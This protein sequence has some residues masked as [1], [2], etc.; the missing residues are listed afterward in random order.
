MRIHIINPLADAPSYHSAE[1]YAAWGGAR[2]TT[3]ADLATVTLAAFVP[4]DWEIR[5]TDEA[6]EPLGPDGDLGDECDIVA[7]TGKVSQRK[8]M[9][10][11]ANAYRQRG[12]LVLMGG[13]YASLSPDDLRPHADILV[14]G[15]IEDIAAGLFADLA[16]GRW[17]DRYVG[18][19]P[20]LRNSPIPRW[21]LYPYHG[22]IMGTLQT[23]RGCPFTCDFCDVIQY[24]GRHQRH[25]APEQVIA[26]LEVLYRHGYRRI[27]LAD[28]NFT[29]YR[30]HA[31]AVLA[32]F[33]AWNEAHRDDPVWFMAQVS[34]DLARDPELM[35]ACKAAGL[36][37]VFIGIETVNEDSLRA[38]G[39]RQNLY[40]SAD[41]ALKLILAHGIM[42][43]AGI[44]VGF[45]ADG[46]D[47]FERL[48]EFFALAPLPLIYIGVLVA[49]PGT[50]LH[51]RLAAEGRLTGDGSE[52]AANPFTTNIIPARM[53]R[54]SLL[55][56]V[57][58]L[59]R[60]AYAPDAFA[61][62]LNNFLAAFGGTAVA[63][64]KAPIPVYIP[65]EERELFKRLSGLGREE[66]LM[67]MSILGAA[68]WRP[69][70]QIAIVGFL[71]RYAQVCHMLGGKPKSL[72]PV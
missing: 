43:H 8:R 26:E 17:Q 18:T 34:I 29:V 3:T 40:H 22:A 58:N 49:P 11:L 1:V 63:P 28:D 21:D 41:E 6:I 44:I 50:P 31:H 60:T 45:D 53:S 7:I 37:A 47:I 23:S 48:G 14:T 27:F 32:A 13:P 20:D 38:A 2:R 15:E 39:K 51:A 67:L 59:C 57:E 52:S 68:T 9:I 5:L 46:P 42:V 16:S 70:A 69:D 30:R 12:K 62:R 66:K 19:R 65:H 71:S 10:A 24:L 35:A 55:D 56:G 72:M 64:A 54:Q 4:P 61:Q 25:K 36:D 33:Q